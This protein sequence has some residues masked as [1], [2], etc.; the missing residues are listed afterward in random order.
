[1]VDQKVYIVRHCK[2]EGQEAS[3]QLTEQGEKQA[4]RLRDFFSNQRVDQIITSPYERAIQSIMPTAQEHQLDLFVAEDLKERK[5]SSE[6][7]SDWMDR[8]EQTY[9]DFDLKLT[10]GESSREAAE[11]ALKVL[12]DIKLSQNKATIVVSHG[13]LISLILN[14]F[15]PTFGFKG[16]KELTNPDIYEINLTRREVKRIWNQ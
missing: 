5:L 6:N 14:H 13:G 1:M 2:A 10:G 15:D 8:L 4:D 9:Q 3:S 11:R 16:W 7:L 12:T